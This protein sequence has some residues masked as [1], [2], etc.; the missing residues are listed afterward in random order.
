MWRGGV[1]KELFISD[2]TTLRIPIQFINLL[3]ALVGDR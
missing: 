2:R 3:L 1:F